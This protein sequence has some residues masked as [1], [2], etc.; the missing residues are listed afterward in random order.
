MERIPQNVLFALPERVRRDIE[1]Q[2]GKLVR[3]EE[4]RLHT[5]RRATLTS[6]G[7]NI[8]T[9]VVLTRHEIDRMLTRLCEGSVYA[10]R[11]TIAEGYV[12]MRG[13]VRVGVCGRAAISGGK[14]VGVYD[15]D[16]LAIRI[17]HKSPPLGHEVVKLIEKMN[18]TRGVLIYSPPGVGK[19]TLLRSVSVL[20]SSGND[21]RRVSVVDTRGE[22][23]FSLDA[24]LLCLDLLS[25]YPK[26]VGISLAARTLGSQVII[27]DEIG[28]RAEA[29]A[30]RE[31]HNC[32]IPLIASS[33]GA[34]VHELLGRTG[35]AELHR[36]GAF[37]AYVGIKRAGDF[38]FEYDICMR[39]D[40]ENAWS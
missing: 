29:D 31:A 27:C 9:S 33:H 21:A 13:G 23:A 4:L 16:T 36:S 1:E 38:G 20:L 22:L 15:I 17:P 19:T 5:G 10:Y 3:V 14:I 24:P 34:S 11:D 30:I 35:I 8:P 2:A 28:N 26:H 12:S 25:G 32:G 7:R 18:Y 6:A 40:A 39:E 37:G